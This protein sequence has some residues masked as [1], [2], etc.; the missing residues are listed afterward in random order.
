MYFW[1]QR[2]LSL[3]N[4]MVVITGYAHSQEIIHELG[5]AYPVT[6]VC[7]E[8][9]IAMRVKAFHVGQF[10]LTQAILIAGSPLIKGHLYTLSIPDLPD[11][12]AILTTRG[13][14][15]TPSRPVQWIAG[16]EISTELPRWMGLPKCTGK[17]YE[18]YGCGPAEYVTFSL[19]IDAK[20]EYL[21]RAT[22]IDALSGTSCTY[23]LA[24]HKDGVELGHGMCSGEFAFSPG[25]HYTARFDLMDL[26][27]N[28]IPGSDTAIAFTAPTPADNER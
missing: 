2:G 25:A 6:L 24:P 14:Y 17:N 20:A 23:L 4:A 28:L 10:H 1:P 12:L 18:M 27:G 19:P 21:V 8:E 15:G 7:G 26:S 11:H 5:K 16:T 3:E 9:K 22:V 13:A